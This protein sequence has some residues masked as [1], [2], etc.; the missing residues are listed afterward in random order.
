MM[1]NLVK[2]GSCSIV[3]GKGHFNNYF[4]ENQDKLL[5]ITKLNNR[6]N[7]YR[8][9]NKIREIKNYNKY[10]SI[11]DDHDIIII[12][13]S[14]PFFDHLVRLTMY[15]KID[16]FNSQLHATYIDYAGNHD[17]L[18]TIVEMDLNFENSFWTSYKKIYNFIK[19]I[20][21]GIMFLHQKKICHLDI[22]PENIM[23]NKK[24][25]TYKIID[26]GFSSKE[27]FTD[28]IND[29]KGTPGYFPK[30]YDFDKPSAWLPQ[31]KANDLIPNSFGVIPIKADRRLVYKIDSYC[32]GR[33]LYFF[34]YM[35]DN[36]KIYYCFSLEKTLGI[37]IDNIIKTL[38]NYDIYN[39]LTITDCYKKYF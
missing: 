17:L 28:Y 36:N 13:V 20:I 2:T 15:D 10:Y 39:R 23:V 31:I 35:Y 8:L 25:T 26:F 33:S 27:P 12:D 16:I 38:L 18:D 9:T 21:E 3:L 11:P 24:T 1:H 6:H 14:S 30:Q 19:F 34:K 37:K 22:K 29:L 7:E 4:P 32:L 5:K